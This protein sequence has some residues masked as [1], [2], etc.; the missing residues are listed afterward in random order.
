MLAKIVFNSAEL[1][2]T[3]AS[4][5][6]VKLAISV[7]GCFELQP[8]ERTHYGPKQNPTNGNWWMLSSPTYRANSLWA[9]RIPPTVEAVRIVL[10]GLS[11]TSGCHRLARW[12]L[13][14]AAI[15]N[16]RRILK[17]PPACPVQSH[18]GCYKSSSSKTLKSDGFGAIL[19]V[20]GR[21]GSCQRETPPGKPV[22]SWKS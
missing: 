17:M 1:N 18:V 13:T 19:K 3:D 7:G 16:S 22:A 14:L 10:I 9:K 4:R 12:S 6:F 5:R 21:L 8:T 15:K 11:F 2:T 20:I